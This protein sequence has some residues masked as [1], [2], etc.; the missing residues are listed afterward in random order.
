MLE[1]SNEFLLRKCKKVTF[2]LSKED[3]LYVNRMV[4]F[5]DAC[6]ENRDEEFHIRAGI[7][8]AAPQVGCDKRII[9][10]HFQNG[11]KECKYLL[12]NPEI[13]ATSVACCYLKA[14]EGCLSVL[15]NHRGH[16]KRFNK[17]RVKA[18][19]ML[20]NNKEI[21]ITAE[22]LLS[23]CFQHEI[24]HLSGILFY[25]R[26]DKKHKYLDKDESLIAY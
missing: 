25:H 23:V 10:I 20:N 11:E 14:G 18:L 1:D 7:A 17:V 16:I 12:A 22:G 6:Y 9:Y 15:K 3:S 5:I 24:D 26:I 19:D 2:P 13:V 4:N 21:T 8:I